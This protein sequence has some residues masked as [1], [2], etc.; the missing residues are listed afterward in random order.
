MMMTNPTTHR[1][2]LLVNGTITPKESN[3]MLQESIIQKSTTVLR[4]TS[5]ITRSAS[6]LVSTNLLLLLF[7]NIYL[8]KKLSRTT[9]SEMESPRHP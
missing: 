4:W 2:T 7:L 3:I 5:R 6:V 8:H 9:I 1:F